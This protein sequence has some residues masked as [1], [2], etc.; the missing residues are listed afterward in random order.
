MQGIKTESIPKIGETIYPLVSLKRHF[1][2][3]GESVRDIG[4]TYIVKEVLRKIGI[5][6]DSPFEERYLV[7][8]IID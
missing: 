1:Q 7:K 3:N 4:G 2:E 8:A 6:D 5:R